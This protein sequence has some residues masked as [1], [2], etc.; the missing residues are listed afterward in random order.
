VRY[1]LQEGYL[2]KLIRVRN[3]GP[4][5]VV[6]ERV[7]PEVWSFKPALRQVHEHRDPSQFRWLINIFLRG[8]KGGLYA[9]VENTIYQFITKGST[10]GDTHVEFAYSPRISLKPGDEYESDAAFLGVYR[11]EGIYLFKELQKLESAVNQ[12]KAI[13]SALNFDQEILD[14]GEVWAMQD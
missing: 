10:P 5:G 14:W 7:K 2:T 11:K 12:P 13:P 4:K 1:Q 6:L 3:T 9:G 8:A